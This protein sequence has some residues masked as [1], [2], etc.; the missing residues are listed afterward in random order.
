MASAERLPPQPR[1]L[2]FLR[3]TQ[4]STLGI[5]PCSLQLPVLARQ[6]QAVFPYLPRHLKERR[7]GVLTFSRQQSTTNQLNTYNDSPRSQLRLFHTPGRAFQ[8]IPDPGPELHM[9]TA[10]ETH[11]E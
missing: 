11:L 3:H 5:A 6:L 1:A 9:Q 4:L 2:V 7:K 8:D 10:G